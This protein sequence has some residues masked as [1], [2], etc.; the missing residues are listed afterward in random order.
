VVALATL[1][2][3]AC[4]ARTRSREPLRHADIFTTYYSNS[5][6]QIEEDMTQDGETLVPATVLTNSKNPSA[7]SPEIRE[8][9]KARV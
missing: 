2:I 1:A 5:S 9:Y 8:Q 6:E 7:Q 4:A 3:V